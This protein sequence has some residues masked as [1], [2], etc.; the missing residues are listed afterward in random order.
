MRTGV[1]TP[2]DV[3]LLRDKLVA[4]EYRL[5]IVYPVRIEKVVV[6]RSNSQ[7]ELVYHIVV[8]G[9][10]KAETGKS[11][12][13]SEFRHQIHAHPFIGDSALPAIVATHQC[14]FGRFEV[15]VSGFRI[16]GHL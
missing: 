11:L 3:V 2:V 1:A 13:G 10:G 7:V 14:H 15:A 5:V 8:L 9:I 16:Q 12:F 6:R 4:A